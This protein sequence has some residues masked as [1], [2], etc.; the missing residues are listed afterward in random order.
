MAST[1]SF[2][3]SPNRVAVWIPEALEMGRKEA[4]HVLG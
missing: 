2:A 1:N 4:T 3:M